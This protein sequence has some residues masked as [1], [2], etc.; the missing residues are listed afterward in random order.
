MHKVEQQVYENI[1]KN[2]LLTEN[3]TVII[4]VSGGVD[5]TVLLHVLHKLSSMKV[6]PLNIKVAHINHGIRKETAKRD[7]NFVKELCEKMNLPFYLLA[8]NIPQYAKEHKMTEEEAGR[9]VRYNFFNSLKTPNSKIVT[10]HHLNDNIETVL[11]RFLKGAGLSGLTGIKT[12]RENVV[13]PM[14]NIKKSDLIAY[15][16]ENMISFVEDETNLEN[17]YTRNKLRNV[18]VPLIE[19]EVNPSFVE[20]TEKMIRY[21]SESNDFIKCE[22]QKAIATVCNVYDDK[23]EYNVELFKALHPCIRNEL[24]NTTVNDFTN[25]EIKNIRAWFYE[26][27]ESLFDCKDG[28]I[29]KAR[30]LSFFKHNGIVTMSK[31]TEK[32]ENVH[33]E[34]NKK[35]SFDNQ[36]FYTTKKMNKGETAKNYIP[37]CSPDDEKNIVLR[38]CKDN[39]VVVFNNTNSMKIN[40]YFGMMKMPPQNRK[41]CI[42]AAIGNKVYW[43]DGL[44]STK[45]DRDAYAYIFIRKVEEKKEN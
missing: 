21:L 7:E 42:V 22:T 34:L 11:M 14:L 33:I 28:A 5:S 17:D 43:I 8:T 20:S 31:D 10:A 12:K 45:Y 23:I 37:I 15:A 18:I 25:Y 4:G 16:N 9:E 36:I 41:Q 40:K 2:K 24:L 1:T 35:I 26:D 29:F 27:V 13:R 38:Y 30:G 39:D 19:K 44:M 32:N 6:L 3:D